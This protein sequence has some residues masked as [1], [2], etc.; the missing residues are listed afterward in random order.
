MELGIDI[1]DIIC[2]AIVVLFFIWALVDQA[3]YWTVLRTLERE[4]LPAEFALLA[5]RRHG[6]IRRYKEL[7]DRS[8]YARWYHRHLTRLFIA[9]Y[10]AGGVIAALFAVGIW[11]WLFWWLFSGVGA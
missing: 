3:F 9:S 7:C 8:G 10:Y 5:S 6:Q 11:G 4:G 2:F 1:G